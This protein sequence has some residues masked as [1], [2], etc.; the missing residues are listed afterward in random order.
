MPS[1]P[2][3]GVK[4]SSSPPPAPVPGESETTPP[5]VVGDSK[6]DTMSESQLPS[7][8]FSRTSITRSPPT[9]SSDTAVGAMGVERPA[10]V[11]KQALLAA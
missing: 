4:M 11:S 1:Q 10:P 9:S 7:W 2:S 8:S 3:G 5:T 6:E